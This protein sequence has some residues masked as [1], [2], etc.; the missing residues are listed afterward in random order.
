ME[1]ITQ[2]HPCARYLARSF[3]ER[4]L[5]DSRHATGDL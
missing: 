1:N 4:G 3:R 2:H 5:M